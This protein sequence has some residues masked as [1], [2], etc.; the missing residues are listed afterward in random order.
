MRR[1]DARWLK[2]PHLQRKLA[3]FRRAARMGACARQLDTKRGPKSG[4]LRPESGC[5]HRNPFTLATQSDA[6]SGSRPLSC[7]AHTASADVCCDQRTCT[8]QK[9]CCWCGSWSLAA[10]TRRAFARSCRIHA[11]TVCCAQRPQLAAVPL[12]PTRSWSRDNGHHEEASPAQ[13]FSRTHLLNCLKT[14]PSVAGSFGGGCG[15]LLKTL[16]GT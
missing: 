12:L 6:A 10:F 2:R 4:R 16:A 1:R 8:T 11:D 13:L 15:L 7:A 9:R 3:D 14:E 5:M